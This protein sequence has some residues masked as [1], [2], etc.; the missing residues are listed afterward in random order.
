MAAQQKKELEKEKVRAQQEARER[1]VREWE[2]LEERRRREEEFERSQVVKVLE[3]DQ[4]C[5]Q[6]SRHFHIAH[7]FN[8]SPKAVPPKVSID[9]HSPILPQP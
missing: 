5:E 2:A 9:D 1:K 7:C 4:G 6:M 8:K 3:D